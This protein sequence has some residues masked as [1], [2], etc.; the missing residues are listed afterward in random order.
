M[1]IKSKILLVFSIIT[2]V[3]CN[4]K[5]PC[6]GKTYKSNDEKFITSGFAS[7]KNEQ[8]AAD[9]ALFD[10]KARLSNE[11]NEYIDKKFKH[12]TVSPDPAYF[13]KLENSKKTVLQNIEIV[14]DKLEF[15][16]EVYTSYIAIS[17]SKKQVESHVKDA[18]TKTIE[19]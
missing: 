18:L 16:K 4:N 14:C 12:P 11:L 7:S 1:S 2:L 10:A 5:L 17:I 13:S 3:S 6:G 9:K 19:Q 8:L 15:K